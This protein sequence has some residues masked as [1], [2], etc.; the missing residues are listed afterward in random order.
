MPG[1]VPNR[2]RIGLVTARQ[3]SWSDI[4]HLHE[5]LSAAMDAF[6]AGAWVGGKA[7]ECHGRLSALSEHARSAAIRCDDEFYGALAAQHFEVP[8][9]CWQARWSPDGGWI[10]WLW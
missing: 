7:G 4:D 10:P 8:A 9:D 1:L 5:L 2:Y 6:E 3:A